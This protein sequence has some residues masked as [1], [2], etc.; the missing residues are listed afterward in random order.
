MHRAKEKLLDRNYF[1]LIP[2]A[3]YRFYN[4][5]LGDASVPC[6]G[7]ALH[8][9]TQIGSLSTSY[10]VVVYNTFTCSLLFIRYPNVQYDR[11]SMEVEER[12]TGL[13]PP[14]LLSQLVDPLVNQ[15]FLHLK[16]VF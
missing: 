15:A 16:V 3:G 2:Y 9:L 5:S 10:L 13:T 4:L 11:G 1:S 12:E 7:R 8:I 6:V 14:P